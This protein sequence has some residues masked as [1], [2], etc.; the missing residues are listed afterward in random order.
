MVICTNCGYENPNDAIYCRRCGSKLIIN[1]FNGFDRLRY[2][3]SAQTLWLTR[4]IAYVIDS[5]IVSVILFVLSI[6]IYIP[7]FI[8]SVVGGG[9]T[10]SRFFQ[11]PFFIGI[12]L[13]AYFTIM[14]GMYGA[15]IG[16]QVM[17][18]RV[19]RIGGGHPT[20][21]EALIRSITK[22][23]FLLLLADVAVGLY[24]SNDPRDKYTDRASGTY[25]VRGR[26]SS[27]YSFKI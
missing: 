21:I 14:E 11:I 13:V 7:L 2:D 12:G 8:S 4:V 15:T 24:F 23:H 5:V 20:F 19:E 18:V 25:V 16:K 10:W 6:L 3:I 27:F 22:I 26:D 1:D 9:W 17:G